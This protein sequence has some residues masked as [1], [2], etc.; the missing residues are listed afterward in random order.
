MTTY[1][2]VVCLE[3]VTFKQKLIDELMKGVHIIN[4]ETKDKRYVQIELDAFRKARKNGKSVIAF[5]E[6][7]E[8]IIDVELSRGEKGKPW[9]EVKEQLRREQT[10]S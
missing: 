8:D 4:D 6:N 2:L 5:L 3:T 7:L 9:K 10:L 1:C